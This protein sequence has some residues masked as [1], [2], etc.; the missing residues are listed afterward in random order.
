MW[1]GSLIKISVA[2]SLG[3]LDV[4]YQSNGS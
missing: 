2:L 4:F 1:R 3:Y